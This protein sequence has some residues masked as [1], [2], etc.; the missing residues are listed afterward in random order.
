MSWRLSTWASSLCTPPTLR[1][2][3]QPLLLLQLQLQGLPVVVL[4]AA[5][6]PRPAVVQQVVARLLLPRLPFRFRTASAPVMTSCTSWEWQ[7]CRLHGMANAGGCTTWVPACS[8][9]ATI[10]TNRVQTWTERI[11]KLVEGSEWLDALRLA[12]DHYEECVHE[13]Q[14]LADIASERAQRIA[15]AGGQ[16]KHNHSVCTFASCAASSPLLHSAV[17]T[18]SV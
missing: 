2:L 1:P 5:L 7:S 15:N 16:G 3:D 6:V 8:Q 12:L 18:A 17:I 4:E 13:I 10:A 14:E 9:R 11:D